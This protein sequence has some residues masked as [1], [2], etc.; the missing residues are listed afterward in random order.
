MYLYSLPHSTAKL[1]NSTFLVILIVDLLH[2]QPTPDVFLLAFIPITIIAYMI[3]GYYV[4]LAPGNLYNALVSED[5]ELFR[6]GVFNYVFWATVVLIIKVIRGVLRESSA[7]QLRKRLT[8]ALHARYFGATDEDTAHGP[9][10][11]YRIATELHIDNPDQRLAS[12]TRDFSTSLFNILAGGSAHGE[13][14]GGLIEASLSVVFYSFKV[15]ERT[16]WYG[17]IVAYFWSMVVAFVSV[18]VINRTSPVLFRQERLEADFRFGHAELRRHAEEVA[19]L[20]GAPFERRKHGELLNKVLENTWAVIVRHVFLNLVQYGFSY[21]ISVIMY[22]AIALAVRTSVVFS[23]GSAF[24]S[25]MTPG[26]KAQWVSQTGGIFIQLLYSFTMAI[27][28]GTATSIF[29]TNTH[30]VATLLGEL[31]DQS[32][33]IDNPK[34]K[35]TDTAPLIRHQGQSTLDQVDCHVSAGVSVDNLT[36]HLDAKTKVGPVSF[37]MKKGEWVL[38]DGPSGSGKSTI[39][40]ALRG[41]WMPSSGTLK[42]PTQCNAVMFV[43]QVPYVP[44]GM[45]SIRELVMYPQECSCESVE[46]KRIVLALQSVGWRR[47]DPRRV[48]DSREEWSTR[49]SPGE[50][51]LLAAARVLERKPVYVV[52]DEPTSSLD[53]ESE[54]RVL[55][56][57]KTAGISALTVGHRQSLPALHDKTVSLQHWRD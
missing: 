48:L 30:R 53:L 42:M 47:G 45:H 44:S 51:Q 21:Y 39:V 37:T 55:S 1:S 26:E 20:R 11:Y 10:P 25:G 33:E 3:C 13:N 43:P 12:D 50:R 24:A 36:F 16:S 35:A 52:M 54:K 19:F 31:Q 4:I 27:E 2:S 29:I 8:T 32:K 41:L 17:V 28:L 34:G 23:T 9:S 57:I 14:S 40:R 7:N 22:L 15:Y 38:I 56:A 5:W 49:L 46:T 6:S 18:Y